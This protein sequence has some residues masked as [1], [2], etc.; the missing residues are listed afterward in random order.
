[1]T[2]S[3]HVRM[4]KTPLLDSNYMYTSSETLMARYWNALKIWEMCLTGDQQPHE[5]QVQGGACELPHFKGKQYG[6]GH[7]PLL[8]TLS[9]RKPPCR[10][11]T[12]LFTLK[13]NRAL[14]L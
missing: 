8:P 3:G 12:L 11:L 6:E 2:V 9:C 5:V 10:L 7:V 14:N 1:M 4:F 13:L